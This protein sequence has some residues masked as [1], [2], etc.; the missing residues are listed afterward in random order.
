VSAIV[1]AAHLVLEHGG[2][3]PTGMLAMRSAVEVTAV[4]LAAQRC[5][6]SDVPAL[7][8]ALAEEAEA[9]PGAGKFHVLHGVIADVCRNR[10]LR[11]FVD[12]AAELV[13]AHLPAPDSPGGPVVIP[14]DL[15]RAHERI[16]E[17]IVAGD[18]DLAERRMV[19]HLQAGIS[20]YR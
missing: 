12:V 9:T 16:V 13:H 15:H 18:P 1:H 6:P 5:Q 11:L 17:A 7:H 20:V 8:A 3:T 4:R 2:V 14:D 19:R 10:P